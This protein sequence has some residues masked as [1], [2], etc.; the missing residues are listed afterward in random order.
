MSGQVSAA[1]LQ[2][3]TQAA[4]AQ[5]GVPPSI[6]RG[7][8]AVESGGNPQAENHNANGSI[9]RGL[10]QI[11]NQ[12][13]PGISD[14][15]AFNPSFAVPWAAQQLAAAKKSTGSWVGALETY[16]SGGANAWDAPYAAAVLTAGGG[17]QYAA[18]VLAA[19]GVGAQVGAPSIAGSGWLRWVLIGLALLLGVV[20]IER[21]L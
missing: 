19:G 9:D 1:Q 6:L 7:L 5:Y 17:T 11:N 16:N 21:I 4:G 3:L 12:A 14:A 2:S 20:A 8:I 13:H 15:Q 18:N 10:V